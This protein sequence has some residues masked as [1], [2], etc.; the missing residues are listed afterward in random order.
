M[1]KDDDKIWIGLEYFC[2]ET[3]DLW[4]MEDQELARFAVKEFVKIDIIDPS[5]RPFNTVRPGAQRR[6]R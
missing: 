4:K 3:D 5:G 6:V 2:N 1:V